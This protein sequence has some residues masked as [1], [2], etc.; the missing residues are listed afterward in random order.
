M[1]LRAA[2]AAEAPS[3]RWRVEW[4]VVELV[5]DREERRR[6]VAQLVPW[7]EAGHRMETQWQQ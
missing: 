5:E 7:I 1:A 6:R 3:A 4:P 2:E